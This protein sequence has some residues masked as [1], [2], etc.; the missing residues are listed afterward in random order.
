MNKFECRTGIRR[1]TWKRH[2]F[3]IW[4]LSENIHSSTIAEAE[5]SFPM[6]TFWNIISNS[7]KLRISNKTI[8]DI[9]MIAAPRLLL[10]WEFLEPYRNMLWPLYE[11]F[12]INADLEYKQALRTPLSACTALIDNIIV[13]VVW[14]SYGIEE[15]GQGN[16]SSDESWMGGQCDQ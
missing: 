13:V 10:K 8:R 3:W 7:F 6:R 15:I 9:L 11:K 14:K 12:N 2:K 16:L 5:W 1:T 4:I